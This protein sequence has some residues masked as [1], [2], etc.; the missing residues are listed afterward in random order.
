MG[1]SWWVLKCSHSHSRTK[2]LSSILLSS[3]AD[4]FADKRHWCWWA[5]L[6]VGFCFKSFLFSFNLWWSSSSCLSSSDFPTAFKYSLRQFSMCLVIRHCLL[7]GTP[8]HLLHQVDLGGWQIPENCLLQLKCQW[9]TNHEWG[10]GQITR[11]R[12]GHHWHN[13]WKIG[14]VYAFNTHFGHFNGGF[15]HICTVSCDRHCNPAQHLWVVSEVSTPSTSILDCTPDLCPIETPLVQPRG[16]LV[17][18]SMEASKWCWSW[19]DTSID[20][21]EASQ[22]G[23][24]TPHSPRK[25]FSVPLIW[26]PEHVQ[27]GSDSSSKQSKQFRIS[28]LPEDEEAARR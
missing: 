8:V 21:A 7:T 10:S 20:N 4:W 13:S 22:V 27:S 19:R 17:G 25:N 9:L 28:P 6:E 14:G 1:N 23:C 26:M 16:H 15:C 11:W 12:H 24:F 18:T 5:S 3:T 2:Q